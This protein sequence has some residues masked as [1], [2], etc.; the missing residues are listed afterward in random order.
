[1]A[2]LLQFCCMIEA[3]AKGQPCPVCKG[4]EGKVVHHCYAGRDVWQSCDACHGSGKAP[5]EVC[6]DSELISVSL[7]D[8]GAE[9]EN[10]RKVYHSPIVIECA[11]WL[12]ERGDPRAELLRGMKVVTA[13]GIWG[14]LPAIVDKNGGGIAYKFLTDAIR[15]LCRRALGVLTVECDCGPHPPKPTPEQT[16]FKCSGRGWLPAR[17]EACKA[18]GG[19][20]QT[21]ALDRTKAW[22]QP[23]QKLVTCDKCHGQKWTK[24]PERTP[25]T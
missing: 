16:C 3:E 5:P 7:C 25:Q 23:C 6:E 1:M 2:E 13:N 18:C 8:D 24:V 21:V 14:A 4:T 9:F 12:E 19:C 22:P 10:Y 17:V 20:G 11:D 15:E